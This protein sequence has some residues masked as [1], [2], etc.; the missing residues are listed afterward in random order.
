V[1][2][3]IGIDLVD[4]SRFDGAKPALLRRLFTE[5]EI[6]YCAA[7]PRREIHL[8][9]RFAAKEAFL[10]ALGTGYSGKIGW[11]DVRTLSR[12]DGGVDMKLS[13]VAARLKRSRSVARIHVSITHTRAAAAAVVVLEAR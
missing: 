13:G 4:V 5:E 3:G 10:K 11:K 12:P 7:K 1:I 2:V 8:A 6:R 9:G